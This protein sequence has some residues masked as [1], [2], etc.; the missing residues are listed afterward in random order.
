MPANPFTIDIDSENQGLCAS[1]VE[2]GIVWAIDSD[3]DPVYQELAMQEEE[4]TTSEEPKG[5][6]E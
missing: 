6:V 2:D 1:V 3:N 4:I 5:F